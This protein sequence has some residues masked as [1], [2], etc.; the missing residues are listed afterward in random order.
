MGMELDMPGAQFVS[1]CLEK[2]AII[3]CTHDTVLRFVPPLIAGR[4][5]VNRMA[6]ILEDVFEEEAL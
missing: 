1:R 4:A 6:G 2:G 3:N 5:E